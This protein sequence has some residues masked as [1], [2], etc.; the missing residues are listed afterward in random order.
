MEQKSRSKKKISNKSLGWLTA[1]SVVL[2]LL[3]YFYIPI[4]SS[5]GVNIF[6]NRS[7]IWIVVIFLVII[8]CAIP[9]A[10]CINEIEKRKKDR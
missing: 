2:V 4:L 10:A 7:P 9:L 6:P 3:S 5:L 8:V 1:G